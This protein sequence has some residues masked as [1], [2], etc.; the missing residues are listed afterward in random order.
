[1]L[2]LNHNISI[3]I[4]FTVLNVQFI[5]IKT[6]TKKIL[7]FFLI[8][9]RQFL[10][11]KSNKKTKLNYSLEMNNLKTTTTKHNTISC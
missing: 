2:K 7:D 4:I 11:D 10:Q 5:V 6:K 9:S 1:M 3:V 8:S